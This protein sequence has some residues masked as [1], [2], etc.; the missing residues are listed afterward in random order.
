MVDRQYGQ[1]LDRRTLADLKL[2]VSELVNN[3]YIH[4][5]GR[6]HLKVRCRENS[7]RVEVMDEGWDAVVKIR[8]LGGRSGGHGLRLVD[9]LCPRWGAFAG[10]TH[11]WADL[12]LVPDPLGA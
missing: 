10:S 6:I 9:H 7:M 4:G 3:A 5:K 1:E 12:P 2:V 11:V 8:E